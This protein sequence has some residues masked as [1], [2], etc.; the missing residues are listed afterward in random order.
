MV[1]I[2]KHCGSESMS[3]SLIPLPLD[4]L[5]VGPSKLFAGKKLYRTISG[6]LNYIGGCSRPDISF[7]V[8]FLSRY[9]K[10]DRYA[11]YAEQ[12]STSLSKEYK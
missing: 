2:V 8:L 3:K 10:S 12:E 6:I 4:A 5:D 1:K 7:A 9:R 11:S